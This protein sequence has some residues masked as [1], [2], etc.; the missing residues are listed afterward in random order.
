[1]I[2]AAPFARWCA[3]AYDMAPDISA[4]IARALLR[5]TSE[6]RALVFQGTGDV[7]QALADLDIGPTHIMGIGD[8]HDGFWRAVTS[9]AIRADVAMG[10]EGGILSGHSLG[11]AIAIALGAHRCLMGKPPRAVITFGA[12]RVGIG[13]AMRMLFERYEVELQLYRHGAD[14]VPHLPPCIEVFADWEHPADLIQLGDDS[15]FPEI[16]DHSIARYVA[17]ITETGSRP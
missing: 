5:D 3:D 6:G 15:E 16:A 10:S 7:D 4:G 13:P 9:I 2:P 11:G 14:P 1:M 12:P 17:A 8:V